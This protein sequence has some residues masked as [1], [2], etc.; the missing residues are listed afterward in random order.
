MPGRTAVELGARAGLPPGRVEELRSAGVLAG[1]GDPDAPYEP[2]DVNRI[3]MAESLVAS[4][5][6]L[7]DIRAGVDAGR[8]SFGFIGQLF[9]DP[10]DHL[11]GR[12]WAS[13]RRRPASRW[14]SS[15][16]ST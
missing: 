8:V 12:R 15:G 1:G 9:P 5:I 7:E 13:S 2:A 4:G 14:T 16:R 6:A 3:H 11:P 10:V